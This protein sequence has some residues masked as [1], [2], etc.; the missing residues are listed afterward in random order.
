[1]KNYFEKNKLNRYGGY[2]LLSKSLLMAILY[3]VPYVLI[4]S[5]VFTLVFGVM[6]CYFIMSFGMTG[7]GLVLMHD[8]N[9]NSV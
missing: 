1:V 4:V 8:A 2:H 9:H 3:F 7:L 6:I 5:G